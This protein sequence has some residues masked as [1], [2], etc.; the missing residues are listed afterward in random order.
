MAPNY[1]T[2]ALPV[3]A[4]YND[5]GSNFGFNAAATKWQDYFTDPQLQALIRLALLSNRDLR[6]AAMR[7]EEARAAFGIQRAD[8]YPTIGIQGSFNRSRTPGDLSFTG[9][10]LLAS[11]YQV[12]LGLSS[13]EADFWGRV[14]SL[15]DA[16][17]ENYLASD[18]SKRAVTIGL[19]S[20]VAILDIGLREIDERIVLANKNI[21]SRNESLR[22]FTRRVELGATSKLNLTQVQTLLSQAQVL[23]AQLE[24]SRASQLNALTLLIGDSLPLQIKQ[25]AIGSSFQMPELQSG[26]ASD[27]L[28]NRPDIIA[29]EHL[30]K[31]SNA[32]IGAARAAFFPRITLT[33]SF[34]T[35]S[36]ELEGLFA[37]ESSAWTFLPT[38]SLPIF[39]GGRRKN[40]LKITQA[41]NNL[42]VINYEKTIQNAFR[43]VSDALAARHWLDQQVEIAKIT[44]KTQTERTRLSHL[45][46][47]NGASSFL[48][49]L[50][51]ERDLLSAE[52]QSVQTYSASIKS[53]INLYAALGG[54]SQEVKPSSIDPLSSEGKSTP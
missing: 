19:I 13:W 42:A 26:I 14:R 40:N 1:E 29:A 3:P 2:P 36:A 24:Q 41:R 16:A 37:G 4:N 21:A 27:L 33:G 54:G 43:E 46:Y 15:K 47:D 48:E 7:V 53:R 11:Q 52:Q 51:A 39:D 35:A 20:Q 6:L 12:S 18:E 9:R 10:P 23:G 30:L 5:S 45:R 17:L 8:Q 49:V 31:A 50:D 25:D 28:I 32:N 34:G 38:I 44:L 22:I